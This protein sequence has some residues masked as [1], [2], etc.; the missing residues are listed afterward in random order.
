MNLLICY[1]DEAAATPQRTP[2]AAGPAASRGAVY[3]AAQVKRTEVRTNSARQAKM[4]GTKLIV[5]DEKVIK[6]YRAAM[7][8]RR[9]V[10]ITGDQ[11]R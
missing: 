9:R 2:H 10:T 1:H 3:S 4:R 7:A 11:R 8:D 6:R 5:V